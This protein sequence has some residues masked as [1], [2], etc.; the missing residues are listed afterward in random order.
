MQELSKTAFLH[1]REGPFSADL[2]PEMDE[3]GEIANEEEAPVTTEAEPVVP[4]PPLVV[5]PAL[6]RAYCDA[7][8]DVL[9]KVGT[10]SSQ[11]YAVRDG[12]RCG[13]LSPR[14]CVR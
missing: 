8:K 9:V 10:R 12:V 14:A 4:L 3:S 2:W 1:F 13:A 5:H 7:I 11:L 6:R